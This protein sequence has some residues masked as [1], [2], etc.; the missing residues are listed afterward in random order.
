MSRFARCRASAGEQTTG[1]VGGGTARRLLATRAMRP[2]RL[3][4]L[5]WIL[6]CGG[7]GAVVDAAAGSDATGPE[8]L[9]IVGLVTQHAAGSGEPIAGVAIAARHLD[10]DSLAGSTFSR[11]D[12]TYSVTIA[13]G[14]GD[15]YLDTTG[16]GFV[17]TYT[18][19]PVILYSD[20]GAS[21]DVFT[22]AAY[23]RLFDDA[24]VTASPSAG[25]IE[26]D[27]IDAEG[28]ATTDATLAIQPP[29]GTVS[30]DGSD[31]R[32]DPTVTHT[33]DGR[34]YILDASTGAIEMSFDAGE[35]DSRE[36]RVVAG[37][38]SEVALGERPPQGGD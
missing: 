11:A 19:F 26:V 29:S 16:S 17:E 28:L 8:Q 20:T 33:V 9:S 37:K 27:T 15:V 4:V 30:Y 13:G 31:G 34:G 6:G 10:D 23:A 7:S 24:G 38:V 1:I 2:S 35:T 12:G 36:I 3:V 32:P 21:I 14:D 22:P 18:S 5:M 25:V